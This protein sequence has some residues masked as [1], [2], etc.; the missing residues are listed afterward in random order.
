MALA[1][2]L[3]GSSE[4][5]PYGRRVIKQR[6][7]WLFKVDRL[8]ADESASGGITALPPKRGARP[9]LGWKE[10]ELQHLTE[11]ITYPFKPEWK[12]IQLILY[13]TY[14]PTTFGID[15]QNPIFEWIRSTDNFLQKGLYFVNETEATW[16]PIV[17]ARFKR[18]GELSLYDGCGHEIEKW[19]FENC[20]PSDVQWG[21][22]DMEDS[23]LVTV[24]IQLK[25]DRAYTMKSG[26]NGGGGSGGSG[27]SPSPGDS[28][29]AR[30]TT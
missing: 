25:Y 7:R 21:E 10:Q 13:D 29:Q 28:P 6:F 12:A 16:T 22:L 11:S 19:I 17:D 26:S 24:E 8:I 27:S 9:N 3:D 18:R 15:V 23:Q 2:G 1:F 4:G 30:G 5:T 14:C 20:Y